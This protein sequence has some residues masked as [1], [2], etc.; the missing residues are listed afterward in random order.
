MS[1]CLLKCKQEK[2]IHVMHYK[3][4][5]CTRDSRAKLLSKQ[6]PYKIKLMYLNV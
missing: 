2:V 5:T 1:V 6:S 4:G 3:P